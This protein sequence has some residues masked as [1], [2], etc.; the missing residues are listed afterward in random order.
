MTFSPRNL[1]YLLALAGSAGAATIHVDPNYLGTL[2]DGS[3]EHPWSSIDK[4]F[5]KAVAGD[6]C[7]LEPGDYNLATPSGGTLG[8]IANS[9]TAASPIVVEARVQGSVYIG[10]WQALAWQRDAA[11][12]AL[13]HGTLATPLASRISTLQAVTAGV[14]EQNGARL[15]FLPQHTFLRE[16]TWPRSDDFYPR[17]TEMRNSSYSAY[18]SKI[19]LPAGDLAGAKVHVFRN[20]EQGAVV[21]TVSGR[22]NDYSVAVSDGNPNDDLSSRGATRRFWLSGH[23]S[24]L[25]PAVDK[26]AWTWNAATEKASMV[27]DVDPGVMSLALQISALGPNLSGRSYWTF[28]GMT[29]LGI[30]PVT[31]ETS[32][33]LRFE[34]VRFD[35]PGLHAGLSAFSD[36]APDLSGVVLRGSGNVVERSVFSKCPNSCLE[37]LGSGATV[38][39]S[40][41]EYSQLNAGAYTGAVHVMAPDATVRD[42]QISE[43]G[44][45]GIVLNSGSARAR[46]SNNL[47]DHWGRLSFARGGG[48]VA[49]HKG[50]GTAEIDSNMVFRQ[51]VIDVPSSDPLPGGGINLLFSRDQAWIH[52]NIVDEAVV[53]IRLGGD[54]GAGSGLDNS[55]AN[56]IR[57]NDFGPGVRWSWL[58]TDMRD[59][60]GFT[61][62]T[63]QGNIL[64]TGAGWVSGYIYTASQITDLAA[65]TALEGGTTGYN[66]LPVQDPLFA[67][68]AY[69]DWD[70]GLLAGSPAIDAGIAYDLPDGRKL[71]FSGSAPDIGA[72]EFGTVWRAGVK[73]KTPDPV[74]S[75]VFGMDDPSLWTVPSDQTVLADAAN[76]AEGAASFSVVPSGYK[77]LESSTV[78]Q[79]AVGGTGFVS[80]NVYVPSQQSNPWWVGTVQIF[81]ECPSRGLWNQ[82][83]GQI[84][85]TNLPKDAWQTASLP[86]PA[87]VAQQLKG[88]TYSDLKVRVAVNLNPGSGNLGLDNLRFED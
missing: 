47:I 83:V 7:L 48:I 29:F 12:P 25:D 46:V 76:K 78:D 27:F 39:N 43:A 56:T 84:E 18:Q 88:A 42:N 64:R 63:M 79:T 36:V 9:G 31:D 49:M 30:V 65:N 41:F 80:L 77:V 66:L 13:W 38:R 10:A 71:P 16:F 51:A 85:L 11:K 15:I 68:R 62:T 61:G 86:I 19:A 59:Q 32:T 1:A 53:G 20:E 40:V 35:S 28:R 6:R 26:G 5:S 23:A 45:S 8:R 3:L 69:P 57:S 87:F 4:C 81:V 2:Q 72:V 50:V 21:R 34:S 58:K 22:T 75:T 14:L 24:L 17:T 37:I 70:F 44:V 52:H 60:P 82:W 54:M 73:P 33:G 55:R 67:S 74:P